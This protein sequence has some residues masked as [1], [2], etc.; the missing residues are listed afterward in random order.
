MSASIGVPPENQDVLDLDAL[1]VNWSRQ[2]GPCEFGLAMACNCPDG[3][4]RPVILALVA[5]IRALRDEFVFADGLAE[6]QR[7]G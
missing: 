7:N 4:P 3:D 1:E 6:E 2:C 5:E